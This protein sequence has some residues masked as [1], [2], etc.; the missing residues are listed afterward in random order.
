MDESSV[1][2]CTLLVLYP[3]PRGN[4]LKLEI[5]RISRFSL[6]SRMQGSEPCSKSA[7][8]IR[9]ERGQG[10]M[11]AAR[12]CLLA[13]WTA[14]CFCPSRQSC[15]SC[16]RR[17]Q[18]KGS[19]GDWERRTWTGI[20]RQWEL[21]METRGRKRHLGKGPSRLKKSVPVDMLPIQGSLPLYR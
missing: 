11:S 12:L 15:P 10:A 2:C 19:R 1:E 5:S 17:S 20:S 3:F 6:F 16:P 14:T 13:G 21:V 4:Y 9:V 18:Q 8:A 7:L